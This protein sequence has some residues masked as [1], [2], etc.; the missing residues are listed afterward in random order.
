[1]TYVDLVV[2]LDYF[3]FVMDYY[4]YIHIWYVVIGFG[5][6]C[7]IPHLSVVQCH[8]YLEKIALRPQG[9]SLVLPE[10]FGIIL[11]L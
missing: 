10:F 6:H 4:Q 1:M 2:V 8:F 5:H 9:G 3:Q 11:D 7:L